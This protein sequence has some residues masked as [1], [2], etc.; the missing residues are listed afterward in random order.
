MVESIYHHGGIY[1]SSANSDK[2]MVESVYHRMWI[3]KTANLPLLW[4][5]FIIVET[6]K[7]EIQQ[8]LIPPMTFRIT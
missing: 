4:Y 1:L 5:T 8:W 6:I 3:T 7:G 2:A